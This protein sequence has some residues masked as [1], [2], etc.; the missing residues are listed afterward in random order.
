MCL[1]K[2]IKFPS[3]SF[4]I[5]L[6]VNRVYVNAIKFFIDFTDYEAISAYNIILLEKNEYIGYY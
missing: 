5:L 6:Q 2:F 1:Y 3:F 4:K